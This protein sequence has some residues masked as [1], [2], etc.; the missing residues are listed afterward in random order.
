MQT[1]P[2][3]YSFGFVES[4]PAAWRVMDRDRVIQLLEHRV[5]RSMIEKDLLSNGADGDIKA[6]VK[7]VRQDYNSA[8]DEGLLLFLA[9]GEDL[10]YEAENMEIVS[11]VGRS[12]I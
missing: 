8:N 9:C 3:R 7:R 6:A 1:M 12:G 10:L 4:T 11:F 2:E 5:V